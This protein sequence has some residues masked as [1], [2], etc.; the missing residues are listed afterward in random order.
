M[1]KESIHPVASSLE[2]LNPTYEEFEFPDSFTDDGNFLKFY[3]N[4]FTGEVRLTFP[5][6]VL[7]VQGGILGDEMGLVL[8]ALCTG[9]AGVPLPRLM[10]TLP[11]AGENDRNIGSCSHKPS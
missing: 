4:P 1:E 8:S 10:S 11:F 7:N 5:S 3:Y 2:E 6:M 9:A